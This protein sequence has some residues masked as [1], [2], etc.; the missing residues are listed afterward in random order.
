MDP[1]F[2]LFSNIFYLS[3][4]CDNNSFLKIMKIGYID[5]STHRPLRRSQP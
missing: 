3:L 2:Q 1:R 5:R 4:S